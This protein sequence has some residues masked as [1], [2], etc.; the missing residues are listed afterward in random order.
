MAG[1]RTEKSGP[2]AAPQVIVAQDSAE[3]RLRAAELVCQAAQAAV[4]RRGRF[5]AVLAG[6]RTPAGAYDLL[7]TQAFLGRVPWRKVHVWFGDE[8]CV[9]PDHADSNYAMAR[10]HLLDGVPVPRDQVHR[11][12]A[13]R[14]PDEAARLY[15]RELDSAF[16]AGP[17]SPARRYAFDMVL[18]GMG[19]EGHTASLFPG[20]PALAS[21]Q[22]TAAPLVE[23]LGGRRLTLTPRAIND[24]RLVA[25]L[26]TGGGKAWAVREALKGSA[27]AADLPVRAIRP[28]DGR[29]VW[30]LDPEA[31]AG[32]EEGE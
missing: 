7:R 24:A 12:L 19:G 26:V 18:L 29:V 22:P 23:K 4:E 25:F 10:E 16:G 6:G 14:E 3:A 11:F 21:D 1:S 32:L 27:P 30:I 8:R 17:D 5:D 31:A 15:G 2:E 20:S 28:H 13:E 9:P